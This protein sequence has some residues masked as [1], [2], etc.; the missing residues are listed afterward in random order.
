[1]KINKILYTIILITI[2]ILVCTSCVV[3]ATGLDDVNIDD[4]GYKPTIPSGGK[5]TTIISNILGALTVIGIIAIVIAIALIGFSS[6]LGSAS[7]KAENK[8]KYVGLIIAA[9]LITGG[10]IIARIIISVAET[11]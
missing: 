4:P 7:E 11:L 6:I 1:M 8:E 3:S 2:S 5:A 10:S 9:V